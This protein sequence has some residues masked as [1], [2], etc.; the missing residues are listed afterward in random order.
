MSNQ[1][2]SANVNLLDPTQTKTYNGLTSI[3]AKV[4]FLA[5]VTKDRGEISR[6]MTVAEG[7]EIRYQWVRNVMLTPLKK[8]A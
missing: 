6:F 4:R 2:K 7:R 5:T 1:K 3:A 8:S